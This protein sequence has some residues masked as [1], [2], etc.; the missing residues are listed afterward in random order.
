M[1]S[2]RWRMQKASLACWPWSRLPYQYALGDK[3][4]PDPLADSTRELKFFVEYARKTLRWLYP[5]NHW[6]EAKTIQTK[7]MLAG[8]FVK[9]KHQA[10]KDD[11]TYLGSID[12]SLSRQQTRC[13]DHCSE[14]KATSVWLS[15]WI[16]NFENW[17]KHI[18]MN[19]LKKKITILEIS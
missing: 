7:W 10:I 12:E 3:A 11:I 14:L 2:C 4:H 5:V 13:Y 17:T 16:L 6:T 19:K 1:Q 15:I 18:C 8:K 9:H